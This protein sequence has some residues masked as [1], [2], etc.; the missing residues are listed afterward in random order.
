MDTT[1]QSKMNN[2]NQQ[3]SKAMAVESLGPITSESSENS[4]HKETCLPEVQQIDGCPLMLV[5]VDEG[6][7]ACCGKFRLEEVFKDFEDAKSKIKLPTW[8]AIL[9]VLNAQKDYFESIINAK[10][11]EK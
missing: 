6:V 2:T 5:K 10:K 1:K 4:E 11:E 7:I 9:C 3:N 8:E